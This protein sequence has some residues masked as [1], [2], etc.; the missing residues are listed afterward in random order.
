[1]VDIGVTKPRKW[2]QN[3]FFPLVPILTWNK[4]TPHNTSNFC[5][6]WLF[7]KVWTLDCFDFELSFVVSSHWGLG[8]VGSIP[9]LRFVACVPIPERF[10]TW[11]QRN[12]WRN[13]ERNY[14]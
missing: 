8:V 12:L 9:Y 13:P 2:F 3:H 14:L 6:E 11:V 7:F 4:A 5:F 10:S 1:M